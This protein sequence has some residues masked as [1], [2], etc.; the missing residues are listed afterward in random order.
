MGGNNFLE[1]YTN[2][3]DICIKLGG[4]INDFLQNKSVRAME[5]NSI[6]ELKSCSNIFQ[7]NQ[8]LIT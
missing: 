4:L 3:N 6:L 8:Y 1:N 5:N 2:I 7:C